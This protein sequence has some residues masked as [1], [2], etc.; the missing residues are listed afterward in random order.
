MANRVIAG[1]VLVFAFLS[2]HGVYAETHV[3]GPQYGT[4]TDAND[5]YILYG[6]VT[7][8]DGNS[9]TIDPNTEVWFPRGSKI[10]VHGEFSATGA[11]FRTDHVFIETQ[12]GGHSTITD[13]NFPDGGALRYEPGSSGT[14]EGIIGRVYVNTWS[15]DVTVQNSE[16]QGV[17]IQAHPSISNNVLADVH[18][19]VVPTGNAGWVSGVAGFSGNEY[20]HADRSILIGGPLGES[21]TL[22]PVDGIFRYQ[23]A[24]GINV[25]TDGDLTIDPNTEVWFPRGSKI[26]V[27]GEFSATGAVF[28]TDH[29]FIETQDGG[30]STITDCNFP[31][32][33]AL[34][35]EPGSSG[36][37]THCHLANIAVHDEADVLVRYNDL[38]N[39]DVYSA[40]NPDSEIVIDRNWWGTT[41]E[42]EIEK[43]ITDRTDDF[44]RPYA[45]AYPWLLGPFGPIAGKGDSPNMQPPSLV[46]FDPNEGEWREP[47]AIPSVGN[48]VVLNHG[49][50]DEP[51]AVGIKNLA[52][53]IGQNVADL[54]I[55]GWDWGDGPDTVSDANPNGKSTLMDYASLLGCVAS[56][57]LCVLGAADVVLEVQRAHT[58]AIRHGTYLG[59]TLRRY[60]IVPETHG[61]HMIGHSFGGVVSAEAAKVLSG[62]G[63]WPIKQLTTIDTPAMIFPYAINAVDPTCAERVEVIYYDSSEYLYLV[64]AG[65]PLLGTGANNVLNA[66]LNPLHY[67]LTPPMHGNIMDWYARSVTE[68][69]CD[70]SGYGFGWSFV[71]NSSSPDWPTNQPTGS[72]IELP[73]PQERGCF[74]WHPLSPQNLQVKA[75]NL[76][77]DGFQAAFEWFGENVEFSFDEGPAGT[78]TSY[79]R[80]EEPIEAKMLWAAAAESNDSNS[81]GYEPVACLFKEFEVP[82]KADRV[83]FDVRFNAV[84]Q[85]DLLTLSVNDE[86]LLM[87][88]PTTQG[89]TE[90]FVEAS[91]Y[92]G[93]YAGKGVTLRITLRG[94]DSA[95][96]VVDID[97]LRFTQTVSIDFVDYA[98]FASCWHRVGLADCN[99]YDFDSNDK[100]DVN[101]LVSFAD[102]W[103]K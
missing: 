17:I 61:I 57:V 78:I 48:V 34:R 76:I 6:S 59:Q 88:N 20:T 49:W 5:P 89:V 32:G 80:M 60:G 54:T 103:L 19:I 100:I 69:S 91:A 58:N 45:R 102:V 37:V 67:G 29:V 55:V 15:D 13:C 11:V 90:D 2:A 81:P 24:G 74:I 85:G 33:G 94:N 23:L 101:D 46:Q 99:T 27:H 79:I 70:G 65:G 44:S 97:N 71:L 4:W 43:R 73:P 1:I 39:G 35:Y 53:A 96:S 64:A 12:D 3:S 42:R 86:I 26:A 28:R 50:N 40:G 66:E 84:G 51:D 52:V 87:V 72:L 9:L 82:E 38:S 75:V 30:H 10:A 63:K 93:A 22:S 68:A 14:V 47:F 21:A 92:V 95:D 56:R 18:P 8:P 62:N 41:I 16:L 83:A 7:I 36:T 25:L 77:V 98:N 31:D